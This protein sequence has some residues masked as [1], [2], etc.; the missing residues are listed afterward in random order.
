ML[1]LLHALHSRFFSLILIC[2]QA[3]N[4]HPVDFNGKA[5][6]Y[7]VLKCGRKEFNDKVNKQ[8]NILDPVFGR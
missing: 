4:L 3:K 7:L 2:F 6:P 8:N 5:D 1:S